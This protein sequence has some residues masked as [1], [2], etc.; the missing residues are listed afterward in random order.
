VGL[1]QVSLLLQFPRKGAANCKVIP[2]SGQAA[3]VIQSGW[4]LKLSDSRQ[5]HDFSNRL[6]FRFR[7]RI[8]KRISNRLWQDHSLYARSTVKVATITRATQF[9]P[10]LSDLHWIPNNPVTRAQIFLVEPVEEA[11]EC[12]CV[13]GVHSSGAL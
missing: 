8:V 3:K 2:F 5:I 9:I 13:R 10:T 11:F 6:L 4:N 1:S 7:P 12:L